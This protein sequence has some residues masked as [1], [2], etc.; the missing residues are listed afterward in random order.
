MNN[1][2]FFPTGFYCQSL[3]GMMGFG[4]ILKYCKIQV[5]VCFLPSNERIGKTDDDEQRALAQNDH[6]SWKVIFLR[7]YVKKISR[8]YKISHLYI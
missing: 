2:M 6:T 5:L 3:S 8:L 7:I 4:V 1:Y